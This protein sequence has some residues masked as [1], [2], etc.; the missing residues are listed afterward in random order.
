MTMKSTKP[1]AAAKRSATLDNVAKRAGDSEPAGSRDNAEGEA[2]LTAVY[3][4]VNAIRGLILRREIL[5][6]ERLRQ[7]DLAQRLQVSRIPVREALSVLIAEHLV[8]YHPQRGF[9]VAKLNAEEF[10]QLRQMR[11]LLEAAALR[12]MNWPDRAQIEA[13]T[14][15]NNQIQRTGA[16]GD[17]DVMR[18]HNRE[19]HSQI[20]GCS[21][22]HLIVAEI[23]RLRVFADLYRWMYVWDEASLKRSHKEHCAMIEALRHEDS[24][25]LVTLR[26]AHTGAFD[27]AV[28]SRLPPP[29]S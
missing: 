9:F 17:F 18:E 23:E 1:A 2:G 11:A 16:Q 13:L 8:T 7:A 3:A 5:P 29:A 14:Q 25:A 19:F 12:E 24:A 4:T 28:I 21:R 27:K 10:R 22:L 15:L 6:G 20:L 26:D